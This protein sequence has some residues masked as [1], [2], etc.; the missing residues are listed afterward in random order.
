MNPKFLILDEATSALDAFT[1][2]QVMETIGSLRGKSTVVIVAHRLSTI[3]NADQIIY[4]EK[5]KIIGSG[6]FMELQKKLPQFAEQVKLGQ[7][8]LNEG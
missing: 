2:S 5:G 7:L 6:T 3:K 1:E 4:L 8:E